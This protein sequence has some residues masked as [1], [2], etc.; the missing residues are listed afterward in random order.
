MNYSHG[1]ANSSDRVI[2][3]D[4]H[5]LRIRARY[6]TKPA[7][8]SGDTRP[9]DAFRDRRATPGERGLERLRERQSGTSI[10]H[11]DRP[12]MHSREAVPVHERH[13]TARR[14]RSR[15][16][17]ETMRCSLRDA[18]PIGHGSC[19]GTLFFALSR[20]PCVSEHR[21]WPGA[22]LQIHLSD[23]SVGIRHTSGTIYSAR[24]DI[25]LQCEP[26]YLE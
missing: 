23:E 3:A 6:G 7:D 4:H 15:R 12:H 10:P 9:A 13:A 2:A 1:L 14:C 24:L 5:C 16:D 11:S 22:E 19:E 25:R 17:V 26:E 21:H 20:S 18:G 8:A